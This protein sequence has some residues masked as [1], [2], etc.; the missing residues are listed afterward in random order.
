MA[1]SHVRPVYTLQE[2]Y[3]LEKMANLR[4]EYWCGEIFMMA[5]ASPIHVRIATQTATELNLR[6]R[7]SACYAGTS[8]QRVRI[9]AA[10]LNTYPDV[11]VSCEDARFDPLD[12]YTLLEPKLLVEVLSP[13][14][15]EYDRTTKLEAYK[16]ISTL[17]DYLIVWPDKICIEHHVREGAG[18]A[19][20]RYERRADVLPI[21]S[22][23]TELP[24]AEVY[25]RLDL[26][27]GAEN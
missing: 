20:R 7:G 17:S 27:E 12:S 10:D 6:L 4:H 25:R 5:G 18:W 8:D 13:S 24:L 3:S 23:N 11:V 15:S 26:P 9:E 2:Y 14:T 22:F 21:S 16:R 19:M 1:K